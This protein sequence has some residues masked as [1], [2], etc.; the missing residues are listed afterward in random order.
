MSFVSS[1]R[2]GFCSPLALAFLMC[3]M[4]ACG[5]PFGPPPIPKTEF[6]TFQPFADVASSLPV[7][8]FLVSGAGTSDM[9][10]LSKSLIL[11][12]ID[13]GT[14]ATFEVH[15]NAGPPPSFGIN[16]KTLGNGWYFLGFKKLPSS[17]LDSYEIPGLG[18][19]MRVSG[20][21]HAALA[22][23]DGE[24]LTGDHPTFDVALSER[25]PVT[26]EPHFKLTLGG[27]LCSLVAPRWNVDTSIET[28]GCSTA[29][30]RATLVVEPSDAPCDVCP[31][32]V[33]GMNLKRVVLKLNSESVSPD[34]EAQWLGNAIAAAAM[35]Q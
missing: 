11:D 13:G 22:G 26:E 31:E 9:A 1:T 25:R 18:Y 4:V 5:D 3:A 14:P 35:A 28:Y 34:G 32:L 12:S 27:T 21:H 30:A 17:R 16:V 29:G 8:S 33:P 7:T 6:I 15:D 19:G 20:G 23:I 2:H 24:N 10:A